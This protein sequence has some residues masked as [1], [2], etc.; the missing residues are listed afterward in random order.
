MK[1]AGCIRVA[2]C[3][4]C[5]FAQEPPSSA[6]SAAKAGVHALVKNLAIELAPE[7][8]R[9]NAI[10]P[11]VIETPVYDTFLTPEQVKAVLPTFNAFHPLGRNGQVADAAEALLFLAFGP[12]ELHHRRRPARRRRRHGRPSVITGTPVISPRT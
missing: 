12:G 10:A 5:Q 1:I 2:A 3:S 4:C 8:I 7:K 11:A 9:V 6:Y